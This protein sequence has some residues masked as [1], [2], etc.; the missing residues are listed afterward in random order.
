MTGRLPTVVVTLPARTVAEAREEAREAVV[1]GA[2]LAEVRFD[3]WEAA[4]VDRAMDL[5]PS[6]LPLIATVRS[7]SEGGQGPDAPEVRSRVLKALGRLPFR[8]IDLEVER[9]RESDLGLPPGEPP[10]R[11]LS[12]HRLGPADPAEW[13]RWV[14][15]AVPPGRLRKVVVAASVGE[16]LRTLIPSLPPPGESSVVALTTG[17]SGPLLRVLSARLGLPWVYASLPERGD[18]REDRPPVEPSQIP[19][20]RLRRYLA[21]GDR[22]SLFAVVGHPIAHSKSP[23]LHSR[24]MR[25]AGLGGL[26]LS[27]DLASEKEFVDSL[28]ALAEWGFRGLNVTH[29]WKAAALAVASEVGPGARAVGVANCLTLR[30][31]EVAAENTDLSAILRRLGELSREGRWDGRSVSVIGTGGAARATLAAARALGTSARVYGRSPER[32]DAIAR[33]FGAEAR[34]AA[35][36]EPDGLV[37]HATDVGRAGTGPLVAPL[38]RLLR[39]GTHLIDWV[40][41]PDLPYLR[42]EADRAHATYEEGTRLLVYQ[43]AATF[44]IWWGEEPE[45]EELVRTLEE[46]GCTA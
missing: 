36:A 41:A 25:R 15:E 35:H 4:E 26:Y 13:S 43:A 8:W 28:P 21:A 5:F 27:L 12:T 22:A 30:P 37:V 7:R 19:V 10:G 29:P 45:E 14:R 9:D 1:A 16:A 42:E 32:A 20:D 18:R 11:I 17:P 6:P 2:D 33:D 39:E 40:Y 23:S 44:G 46:E 38:S 31:S 34:S 3:R 24:W